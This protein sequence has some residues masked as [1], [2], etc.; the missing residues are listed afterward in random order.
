[1]EKYLIYEKCV[2]CF[3]FQLQ[4][5]ANV[6]PTLPA[7]RFFQFLHL[8]VWQRCVLPFLANHKRPTLISALTNNTSATVKPCLMNLA[9]AG[10]QV[11]VRVDSCLSM[12]L[13][14]T[15]YGPL[16]RCE[17]FSHAIVFHVLFHMRYSF[18]NPPPGWATLAYN[19]IFRSDVCF[20]PHMFLHRPLLRSHMPTLT[21]GSGMGM[22][23]ASFTS[24]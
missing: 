10:W 19:V 9:L 22:K 13:P 17:W 14:S 18:I 4:H 3:Y 6:T 7:G 16:E 15:R 20:P 11:R 12:L 5:N 24:R 23:G 1:M 8:V 2:S 21:S